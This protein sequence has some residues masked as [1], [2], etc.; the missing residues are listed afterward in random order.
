MCICMNMYTYTCMSMKAQIGSSRAGQLPSLP[1]TPQLGIS[2]FYL[3]DC[4]KRFSGSATNHD[5]SPIAR[6]AN[7]PSF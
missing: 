1:W 3:D 4:I 2:R 7:P 5:P 6:P